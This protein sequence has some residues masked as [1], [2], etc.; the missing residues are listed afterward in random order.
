MSDL[1]QT[2]YYGDV[3]GTCYI[4]AVQRVRRLDWR[5]DVRNQH[6]VATDH[7]LASAAKIVVPE[8]LPNPG[9]HVPCVGFNRRGFEPVNCEMWS[10][11]PSLA[12]RTS[13]TDVFAAR[14]VSS[15]S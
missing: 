8:G 4:L 7:L 14:T 13:P 15:R 1:S 12:A 6:V 2:K 5:R 9:T 11:L 10:R 3:N